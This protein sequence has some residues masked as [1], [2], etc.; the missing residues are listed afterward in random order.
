MLATSLPRLYRTAFDVSRLHDTP[1]VRRVSSDQTGMP[2]TNRDDA[3]LDPSPPSMDRRPCVPP[4]LGS[5]Y[6]M[7][8]DI[9]TGSCRHDI[10]SDLPKPARVRSVKPEPT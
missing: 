3:P 5:K 7:E 1:Y 10:D 4:T 6:A 9:P 2:S 8:R